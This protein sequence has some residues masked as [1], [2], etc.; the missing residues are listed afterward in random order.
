MAAVRTKR[1]FGETDYVLY[2]L[3]VLAGEIGVLGLAV[4]GAFTLFW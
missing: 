3:S 1:F 4:Y 2:R